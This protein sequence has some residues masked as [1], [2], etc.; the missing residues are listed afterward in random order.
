ME[1]GSKTLCPQVKRKRLKRPGKRLKR[2]VRRFNR[3]LKRLNK[4]QFKRRL[5]Q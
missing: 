4:R 1:L 5:F 3:P 2:Q